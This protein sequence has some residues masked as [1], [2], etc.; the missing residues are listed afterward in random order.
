MSNLT[1]VALGCEPPQFQVPT[2]ILIGIVS[3]WVLV[4]V[5]AEVIMAKSVFMIEIEYEDDTHEYV[6]RAIEVQLSELHSESGNE[7]DVTGLSV[8]TINVED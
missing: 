3:D 7:I 1:T 4:A 5:D 2:T 6:K 8:T